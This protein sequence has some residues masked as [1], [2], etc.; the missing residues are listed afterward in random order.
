MVNTEH[1]LEQ[2]RAANPAPSLEQLAVD[3]L[4]LVR[5]SVARGRSAT[6]TPMTEPPQTR[7]ARLT[8]RQGLRPVLVAGLALILVLGTLGGGLLL[9]GGDESPT[10]TGGFVCPP[11]STP[12]HP[13]PADQPRP[14]D[15]RP[16]TFD[17]GSGHVLML[18]WPSVRNEPEGLWTF[19]VCTNTWTTASAPGDWDW[20]SDFVYD[21]D[22]ERAIA[23]TR[24]DESAVNVWAYEPATQ[25]WTRKSDWAVDWRAHPDFPHPEAVYDPVSGL[26]VAREPFLSVMGTYDVD[27]DTWTE[28]DQGPILPPAL[29]VELLTYDASVDRLILYVASDGDPDVLLGSTWEF[30]LRAGRWEEQETDTPAEPGFGWAPTGEEFVYDEANEVSILFAS[31]YLATY[32]ASEQRWT[33]VPHESYAA[34]KR[35]FRVFSNAYDLVNERVLILGGEGYAGQDPIIAF[36]VATGEWIT[37]IESATE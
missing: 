25:R 2:M 21:V 1:V 5:D 4:D 29:D 34:A 20:V 17:P 15:H 23:F 32:D 13:G 7:A 27:T 14:P 6:T 37:L 11:G 28:I 35:F 19:D 12:N 9:V 3:D 26:V 36:D 18:D 30:D 33:V 16:M 8:T 31:R 22:S 24:V 10:A